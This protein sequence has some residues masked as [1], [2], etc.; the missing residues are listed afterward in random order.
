MA[1]TSPGP[2][3]G[4][5][6]AIVPPT[7]VPPGPTVTF[8]FPGNGAGAVPLATA[9]TARGNGPKQHHGLHFLLS[10]GSVTVPGSF[11][12]NGLANNYVWSFTT[13]TNAIAPS[14]APMMS[15]AIPVSG[16][17][18]SIPATTNVPVGN[19]LTATFN[20]V[21]NP[22]TVNPSTFTLKQ[23]STPV[24]GTV[25]YIGQTA[26]FKP[27]TAGAASASTG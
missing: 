21:M 8:T 9:L 10:S 25:S 16:V 12:G 5:V 1:V 19:A 13:G 17:Q 7:I 26:T 23:G 4:G 6:P 20:E 15:S 3:V 22:A 27:A 24:S 14:T 11:R 18:F 2:L